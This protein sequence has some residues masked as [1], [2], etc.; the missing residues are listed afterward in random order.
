ME[1]MLKDNEDKIP[2][3][4]KE[5]INKLIADGAALKAKADA[6]KEEYDN[7]A[8]KFQDELIKLHQ[9]YNA[10]DNTAQA[11]PADIIEDDGATPPQGEVVDAN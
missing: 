7:E 1:T 4:E 11:N 6:T 5:I 3:E 9:K 8:K 10:Q 2:A